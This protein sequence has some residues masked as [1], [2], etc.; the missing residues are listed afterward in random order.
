[1]LY[2]ENLRTLNSILSSDLL[3]NSRYDVVTN[4]NSLNTYAQVNVAGI[5]QQAYEQDIGTGDGF[6][7]IT[8]TGLKGATL[9]WPL[10]ENVDLYASG[11]LLGAAAVSAYVPNIQYVTDYAANVLD[12]GF[13]SRSSSDAPDAD[14]MYDLGSGIAKWANIYATSFNGT[15]TRALYA[16]VAEIYTCEADLNIGYLVS[17]CDEGEYEVEAT[18]E[19]LDIKCVGVVSEKP[20]LLMN[21]EADGIAVALV[22][23]V[24]VRIIGIVKKGDVIVPAGV[25]GAGRAAK[26]PSEYVFGIARAL[27]SKTSNGYGSVNCIIKG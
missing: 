26:S 5:I 25:E 20:A 7:A 16:D 27:E 24:P 23:K 10:R 12:A 22:G 18:N 11:V 3:I 13:L 8:P 4:F 6:G 17:V 19:E 9:T 14:N 2:S 1:M 21:A 15:S